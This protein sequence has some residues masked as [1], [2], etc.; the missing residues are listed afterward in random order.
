LRGKLVAQLLAGTWRS[1]DPSPPSA[2]KLIA[3]AAEHDKVEA[4]PT[5]EELEVIAPLL[6]KSGAAGLAWRKIRDSDL[7]HSS[8]ARQL[9]TAYRSQSLQAALHQRHLKQVIPI[10]RSLGAEPMLVKGWAI[11]RLYPEPGLRPFCDLDLCVSPAHHAAAAAAIKIPEIQECAVDLHLGFGKFYE[12]DEDHIFERS[13]LVRLGDL[14]VRVLGA[15]DDLRFLC[16]HLL[17]HGAARPLWLVDVAVSLESRPD[18][19]DWDRC[20]S[21]SRRH[22]DW[23]A[24]AIGMAHRVL[25]ARLDGIPVAARARRL[26]RWLV[27]PILKE[28]GT[29]CETPRQVA[30]YLRHPLL[31]SRELQ[32]HWP[33]PIEATMTVQGPFNQVPRLVFQIGHIVSRTTALLSQLSRARS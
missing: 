33:N 31:L 10:L 13:R 20:L 27:P 29:P 1:A 5:R 22:A 14:D 21:G 2:G 4:C 7:R 28:W 15:E 6:F 25:G 8:A 18:D 3:G 30:A 11:A 24:C 32:Y 26:P 12:K 23:V 19:F 16:L 17:R 9:Q